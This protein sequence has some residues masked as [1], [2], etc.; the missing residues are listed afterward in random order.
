MQFN[1]S[2]GIEKNHEYGSGAQGAAGEKN[3]R[4][5][6]L[7]LYQILLGQDQGPRRKSLESLGVTPI[8][9]TIQAV[10]SIT[11]LCRE[12]WLGFFIAVY[13]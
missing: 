12:F 5:W 9:S 13:G 11:F 1:A 7:V 8:S 6:F 3:M 4:D 2:F 10:G